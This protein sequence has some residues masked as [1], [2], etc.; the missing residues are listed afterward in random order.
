MTASLTSTLL[1]A[2]MMIIP[3]AGWPSCAVAQTAV[4]QVPAQEQTLAPYKAIAITVPAILLDA[5]LDAFRKRLD[6]IAQR[7]DRVA[8]AELV[9]RDFSGFLRMPISPTRMLPQS[10]T[11]QRLWIS[12]MLMPLG[13]VS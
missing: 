5:S 3:F 10:R 7:R 4:V 11:W 6:D 13:G 12:T 8:L 2:A 1:S 9:A